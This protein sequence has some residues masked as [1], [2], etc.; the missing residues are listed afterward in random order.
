MIYELTHLGPKTAIERALSQQ[1][2]CAECYQATSRS[3]RILP[4]CWKPPQND[5]FK[6]NTD[7]A[8]FADNHETGAGA[9]FRDNHGDAIMKA[10]LREK[11][12]LNPESIESL[13][14]FSRL[15]TMYASRDIKSRNG[16]GI[17][18]CGERPV[19]L[20]EDS[21]SLLGHLFL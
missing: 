15:A 3:D 9:V 14:I 1:V 6:L 8:I 7:G 13:A 10:C 2:L 19:M 11:E 21:S 5:V 18:T 16:G 17:S 4:G 20:T 12:A